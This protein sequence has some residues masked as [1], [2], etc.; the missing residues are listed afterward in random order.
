MDENINDQRQSMRK[1]LPVVIDATNAITGEIMGQIANISVEGLMMITT[2]AVA[3]GSISQM[4]FSISLPGDA[5]FD[6]SIGVEALWCA[7]AKVS[8]SFWVGYQIV[9][10]SDR[11]EQA[12]QELL[13]ML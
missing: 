5:M 7:E 8:N 13:G 9:D 6:F 11:D 4:S 2:Q 10:I 12:L 3:E 1:D